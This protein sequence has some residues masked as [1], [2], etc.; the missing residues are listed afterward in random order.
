M[1]KK[2]DKIWVGII[3]GIVLPLVVMGVFYL[4]SYSYITVPEFLRKMVFGAIILKLLSLC[5]VINLGAFFL[6]YRVEHDKAARGVI[7]ATMVLA[8]VVIIDKL[9]N[10]G[11]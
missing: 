4:S 7:F 1:R 11:L 9:M 2:F 10:G 3:A 6:F 5:A 8:F